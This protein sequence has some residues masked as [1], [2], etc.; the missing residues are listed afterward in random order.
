MYHSFVKSI[1]AENDID[2]ATNALIKAEQR[3]NASQKTI[4]KKINDLAAAVSARDKLKAKIEAIENM[5]V[6]A[7]EQRDAAD[8]ATQLAEKAKQKYQ[9]RWGGK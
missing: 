9:S 8:K 7:Q 4:Q 5:R 3:K 6:R 1:K 2:K